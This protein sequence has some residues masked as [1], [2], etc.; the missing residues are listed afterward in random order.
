MTGERKSASA[1]QIQVLVKTVT[2]ALKETKYGE[3]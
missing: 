2:T 3:N 1:I